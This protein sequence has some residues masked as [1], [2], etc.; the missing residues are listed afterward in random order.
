MSQ[1]KPSSAQLG[2]N[3]GTIITE[4]KPGQLSYALNAQVAGFDGNKVSYQNEQANEFCFKVPDGFI[5]IGDYNILDKNILVIWSVNPTTG[6]SQIGRVDNNS[7]IYQVVIDSKCLGFSLDFPIQKIVHKTTNCSI[8][9]YWADANNRWRWIDLLNLPFKQVVQATNTNPCNIITTPEIDCNKLNVQPNFSIPQIKYEEVASEGNT[10]AGDYQFAI[11]YANS[12]GDPYTSYY[13]VTNPLS[14]SDPFKVTPNFDYPTSKSIKVDISNLDVTNIFGY[15]NLVVIKTINNITSVDLVGTFQIQGDSQTILYTG[16]SKTSIALSIDN[17][18]EKFPTYDKAGD[19][20][21][22]K[23]IIIWSEL[24]TT[25]RVSYQKI[26]N[27]IHLQWVAW[28]LPPLRK[29]FADPLNSANLRGYMRDEVYAFDMVIILDNGY[30]SDRFPIPGRVASPFDLEPISNNDT[31]FDADP[32]A[33]PQPKPRWEVYNTATIVGTDPTFNPDDP[34]HEGPFQFGEFAY[35]ESTDDYPCNEAVWGNLQG[36][37]IRHHKFPDSSVIHHY[38]DL[39]NI[40]PLG[41]RIDMLQVY[42]L[43]RNSPDLTDEQKARIKEIKIVRADAANNNSIVAKGLLFNSGV[44]SKDNATYYYPNYPFN[45]LRPDPFIQNDSNAATQGVIVDISNSVENVDNIETTLYDTTILGGTLALDGNVVDAVYT[46]SFG[47]GNTPKQVRIY[48][49]GQLVFTTNSITNDSSTFWD[50]AVNVTRINGATVDVKTTMNLRGNFTSVLNND[51]T[52]NGVV[53]TSDQH[54][55]ITGQSLQ[56]PNGLSGAVIAS[57]ARVTINR[58][59]AEG[60]EL[61]GFSGIESRERYTFHSPET[62]FGL[63]ELGNILKLESAESGIAKAHFVEVLNHSKYRFPSLDSYLTALGI[64]ILIGFASGT[65]GVSTNV[66]DGGAAFT[67]F[68]LLND[69]IFKLIPKKNFAYQ[70]NAVGNYIKP[71]IIPNGT[72]NKIRQLDIAAYLIPGVQGVGDNNPV[73]NFQRESSVYL[74]TTNQ[75]PSPDSINGVPKDQSRYVLSDVNCDTS[76]QYRPISAYYATIKSLFPDQYGQIYSYNAIDTGFQFLIDVTQPFDI[77]RQTQDIFG[78][79]TFIGRFGL[80][81]KLPFFID[82]RVNFPDEA[83]VFYDELGNIGFP[84][85]WFSTD[86]VRGDG[87]AFNV[88]SIFGVKVNNFDC[89]GNKFFYDSGKIYLFAYGIPYFYV[90]TRVNVDLRQAFNNKEGDFFPHVGGDVPDAWLQES[91]VS[92][93]FDN[94]YTYNKTFS[95]ENLE[96]EF[97]TLPVEFIPGQTCQQKFDNRAVYSDPQEDLINNKRNSWLIYRPASRFDFPLNYGKLISLDG[98]DNGA[99]LARFE[100][101]TYI[102]DTMLT[103]NTSNPQAAFIGNDTLF[104]SAPPID[105]GETDL[106]Y[107]GTQNKFLLRTEYGSVYTDAKRGLVILIEGNRAKNIG[108]SEDGSDTTETF[109]LNN[110][111][112]QLKE[113]FPDY[114]IDNN[115][116]GVGL[117]GV[118]DSFYKRIILTKL[119]YK[120]LFSNIKYNSI[121]DQFTLNGTVINLNDPTY[122]CNISWTLCY[123]LKYGFWGSFHTY[124]PNYY[125]GALNRFYA[126]NKGQGDF[127]RHNTVITKYNNFFGQIAPYIIEYPAAYK[128]QD[129]I[130]QS[131][132]DYTKVN[133]VIDKQ[134]FVQLD[135]VYFNKAILYNDQQNSGLR[136]LVMKPNNNL[137]AYLQYPKFNIDSIDMLWDKCDNI[138]GYNGFWDIVKDYSQPIWLIG[139]PGVDKVLNPANL[140]YGVRSFKKYQLRAKDC[141]IRHI[142]DNRDDVRMTSQFIVQETQ[143][144]YK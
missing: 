51:I 50:V 22:S 91:F 78:G 38:D 121:L 97:T 137:K 93:N 123:W 24:T 2:L 84:K 80:K 73:N 115:F 8:E 56:P 124:L 74:R 90:E 79:D 141:K 52:L 82:N 37:K 132:A 98:L 101:K 66:F 7:C 63:P 70:Y 75:L 77:T 103:I 118:Y 111:P 54:M 19:V 32:C 95:K 42:N 100:N 12:F 85:Y 14:I 72:G 25:E 11:Q 46:G 20:T 86:V 134:S 87:G 81:R 40:Y 29:G 88:G 6:D 5:V 43:I 122:F 58:S 9:V 114:N 60:N 55:V 18:F 143:I 139:C 39:G 33:T 108:V 10:I 61:D 16:Q 35:W 136:N 112:F 41:V 36:K 104:K 28:K 31:Q 133:K 44:Y 48:F 125:V 89:K 45:D 113:S 64:G 57:T 59:A 144:S 62:S 30:Q 105:F 129:E 34:C 4:V 21:T 92:I 1:E 99:V 128:M 126:G 96:N 94:T 135:N 69:I 110:L 138:Y 68:T 120:P 140:D 3:L 53:L 49:G 102:Y 117:H 130:L 107:A 15:F 116:K 71:T 127:W 76:F 17:I 131:I 23:N 83:D 47:Q 106:G 109:F 119:D 13:S 26:A 65:Y 142:L 27:E 67:A